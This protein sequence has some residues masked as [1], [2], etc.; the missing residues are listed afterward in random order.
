MSALVDAPV[1]E[2]IEVVDVPVIS[3]EEGRRREILL[4]AA[5]LIE[6]EGWATGPDGMRPYHPHC[7][8]GAVS[9]AMGGPTERYGTKL[10]S[11]KQETY[12]SYRHSANLL[13]VK[14]RKAYF[15]NDRQ[16][17][18]HRVVKLLR[19]LANGDTW[20]EAKKKR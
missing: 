1:V 13:G 16:G 10:F 7:L 4:R 6:R 19:N 5:D 20:K 12:Y 11:K 3:E 14:P 8:L 18:H 2:T 17:S 9:A 15:F